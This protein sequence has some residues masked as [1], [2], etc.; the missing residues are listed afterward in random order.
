MAHRLAAADCADCPNRYRG[1][2][3]ID[4]GQL[5]R[6]RPGRHRGGF[7]YLAAALSDHIGHAIRLLGDRGTGFWRRAHGARA[8][9]SSTGALG[10]GG[11]Q[12][13]D[14]PALPEQRYRDRVAGAPRGDGGQNQRLRES[15]GPRLP[16]SRH[17]YGTALS[18][19]GFGHHCALC[20]RKCGGL[21]RQRTAEL[22]AD[23]WRVGRTRTR[24]RRLWSRHRGVHVDQHAHHFAVC[25]DGALPAALPACPLVGGA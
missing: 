14:D 1:G 19:P 2:R 18:H 4:G 12:R 3:H 8:Q 17:L 10:G 13:G 11:A 7:Q 24:R 22:H 15:C 20:V 5:R 16:R 21:Y 23:I 6:C 25:V 9:F